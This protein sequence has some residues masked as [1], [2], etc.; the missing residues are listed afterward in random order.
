MHVCTMH[1]IQLAQN[2]GLEC[3]T[4]IASMSLCVIEPWWTKSDTCVKALSV[5][6]PK[7]KPPCIG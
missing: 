6:W 1:A 3:S 4:R 2:A 7:S 5:Y